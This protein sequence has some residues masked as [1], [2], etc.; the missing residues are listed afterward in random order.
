MANLGR[1]LGSFIE[2]LAGGYNA[3][4]KFEQDDA[5]M[6]L[7]ERQMKHY[8]NAD[9][10]AAE[11][12]TWQR[13]DRERKR[14]YEDARLR[15]DQAALDQQRELRDAGNAAY[16]ADKKSY[17]AIKARSI[18]TTTDAQGKKHLTVDGEEVS[19]TTQAD[20]LFEQKHGGFNDFYSRPGGGAEAKRNAFLRQGDLKSADVFDAWRNQ[21]EV[22]RATNDYGLALQAVTMGD[23][24]RASEVLNRVTSNGAYVPVDQHKVTFSPIQS[25]EQAAANGMLRNMANR[26]GR[27]R[28]E[29]KP[30]G[31]RVA[32]EDAKGN[33][34]VKDFT[35]QGEMYRFFSTA[36][37]PSMAFD[38][39]KSTY[40]AS[41]KA[42]QKSAE[43]ANKLAN[44]IV[45][46]R[47]ESDFK[48]AEKR[49]EREGLD[50][51]EIRQSM[52]D[53]LADDANTGG[54]TLSKPQLGDDGQPVRD[55]EGR[56]KTVPL[57]GRERLDAAYNE[58]V[59]L[60][61]R[62]RGGGG[63]TNPQQPMAGGAQGGM[64][65]PRRVLRT[66]AGTNNYGPAAP[67]TQ[68]Q[69]ALQ[70]RSI[71][72]RQ[73]IMQDYFAKLS[74]MEKSKAQA[75]EAQ[76]RYDAEYVTSKGF[77]PRVYTPQEVDDE[78]ERRARNTYM[79]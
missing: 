29:E 39:A 12:Q 46:K 19:D 1:G 33:R 37:H 58:A 23:Y 15:E 44:D 40:D 75:D 79:R 50:P 25:D 56:I 49:A 70:G 9:A 32:Y 78:I 53:I 26:G 77:D 51:K 7:K 20:R 28:V 61:R 62:T 27:E 68:Q 36:L 71:V 38:V 14:P 59:G 42:K 57:E 13:E 22:Q 11:D 41:V 34:S 63:Q 35:D 60:Y 64:V 76:S 55:K 43:D 65:N 17:D 69:S 3:A 18:L 72:Q 8:E 45:L 30:N 48:I 74:G 24:K 6:A 31:I 66:R 47:Y 52:S 73:P 21:K 54:K 16:D 2:N 4:R 67:A 5:L 10:R